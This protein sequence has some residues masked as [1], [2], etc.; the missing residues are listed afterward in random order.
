MTCRDTRETYETPKSYLQV[1]DTGRDWGGPTQKNGERLEHR[2][3]GESRGE[4]PGQGAGG[5]QGEPAEG[6]E[7]NRSDGSGTAGVW[8]V[9]S[10]AQPTSDLFNPLGAALRTRD[11]LSDI[12]NIRTIIQGT[13]TFFIFFDIY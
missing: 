10:R 9:M 8:E 6:L 4:P 12:L 7:G 13:N 1:G 3:Q 2:D 5:G 11:Y